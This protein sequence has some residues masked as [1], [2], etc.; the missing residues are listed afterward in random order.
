[1]RPPGFVRGRKPGQAGLRGQDTSELFFEDCRVP[2][3]NLLGKTGTGFKMLM[4]KLQQERLCIEN[5]R[6]R[7]FAGALLEDTSSDKKRIAK[8]FA[9][10]RGNFKTHQFKLAA[11]R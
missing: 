4:E 7:E 1:M 10:D 2:A 8:H 9:A 11:R 3:G 5:P 6:C